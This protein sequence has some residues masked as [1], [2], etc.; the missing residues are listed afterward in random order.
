MGRNGTLQWYSTGKIECPTA[1]ALIGD[2]L[3]EGIYSGEVLGAHQFAY[4][5]I[6]IGFG[7]PLDAVKGWLKEAV[8]NGNADARKLTYRPYYVCKDTPY[9]AVVL[10]M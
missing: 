10:I 2:F 1:E 7:A 5:L 6:V 9:F 4:A 8:K 3:N